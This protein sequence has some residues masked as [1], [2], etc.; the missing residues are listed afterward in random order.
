MSDFHIHAESRKRCEDCGELKMRSHFY[1]F[2]SMA[3]GLSPWCKDYSK[4]RANNSRLESPLCDC[5]QLGDPGP[6]RI[7]TLCR[8]I[9]GR[10]TAGQRRRAIERA[11]R[12][13]GGVK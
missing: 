9:Q 3:D 6:E 1:V 7:A 13:T 5:P 4:G 2:H 8:E 10:W 12:A 11:R